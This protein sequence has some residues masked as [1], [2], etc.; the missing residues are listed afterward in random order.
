MKKIVRLQWPFDMP[1]ELFEKVH[2]VVEDLMA[3]DPEK[4]SPAG[5]LLIG[6]STALANYEAN[7]FG[8]VEGA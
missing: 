5:Q 6:I 7:Y 2:L 8:F 4:D 3:L 1:N